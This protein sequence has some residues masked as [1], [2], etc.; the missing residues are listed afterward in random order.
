MSRL[1]GSWLV[2]ASTGPAVFA[3]TVCVFE[4]AVR[5]NPRFPL[6]SWLRGAG[7]AWLSRHSRRPP[8]RSLARL[9]AGS[10]VDR[11]SRLRVDHFCAL[12]GRGSFP[13]KR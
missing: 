1:C 3:S 9:V 4:G 2:V 8:M 11:S 6:W 12:E 5:R 13:G 7:G 10:R